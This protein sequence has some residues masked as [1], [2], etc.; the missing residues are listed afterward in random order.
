MMGCVFFRSEGI[1]VFVVILLGDLL[2]DLLLLVALKSL[3][4]IRVSLLDIG[5]SH[6]LFVVVFTKERKKRSVKK[7]KEKERK[8]KRRERANLDG[9]VVGVNAEGDTLVEGLSGLL[10]RVDV[11]SLLGLEET[12][13]VVDGGVDDTV[14]DGLGH[15]E[16]GVLNA[17]EVQLRADVR[18][19]DARVREVDLPQ[20]SLDDVAAQTVIKE[21]GKG[22][23]E[24]VLMKKE[25]GKKKKREGR[26]V[27]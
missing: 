11:S 24:S 25:N 27:G 8:K 14:A 2:G 26:T 20:S 1:K 19:V 6:G 23:E 18:E 17:L 13:S 4:L 5:V 15:D 12:T 7:R 10:A 22:K 3:V 16:G 9:V 21:K